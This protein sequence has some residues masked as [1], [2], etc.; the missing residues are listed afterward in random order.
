LTQSICIQMPQLVLWALN[1]THRVQY[2]VSMNLFASTGDEY[3]FLELSS[4]KLT[5]HVV[6]LP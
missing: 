5:S 1:G 6:C 2:V 3:S 4:R